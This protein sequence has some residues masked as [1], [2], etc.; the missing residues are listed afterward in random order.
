M[1]DTHPSSIHSDAFSCQD[2][3][4][5]VVQKLSLGRDNV[6]FPDSQHLVLH[7]TDFRCTLSVAVELSCQGAGKMAQWVLALAAKTI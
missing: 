3:Y 4:L 7:R 6:C 1:G 2:A 5:Q